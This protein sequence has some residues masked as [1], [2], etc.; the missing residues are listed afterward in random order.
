[1]RGT[2][3][4]ARSRVRRLRENRDALLRYVRLCVCL[5]PA[6][7]ARAMCDLCDECA[8]E[9]DLEWGWVGKEACLLPQATAVRKAQSTR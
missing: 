8:A 7:Y 2:A 6:T 9:P 3:A 1:V 4:I 5:R